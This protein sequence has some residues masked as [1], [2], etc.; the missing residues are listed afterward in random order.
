MIKQYLAYQ[1]PH[2]YDAVD[3]QLISFVNRYGLN[4][5]RLSLATVFLWFGLLKVLN[6]SPVTPLAEDL[7]PGIT[8]GTFVFAL[9]IMEIGVGMSLVFKKLLKVSIAIMVTHLASTFSLLITLQETMINDSNPFLLT[10]EGEFIIK[11]LVLIAGA[12]AVA[13]AVCAE[14]ITKNDRVNQ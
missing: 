4:I 12:L 13:S 1:I 10:L 3:H 14:R 6:V 2:S 7:I 9:G 11:N 5:L 8:T